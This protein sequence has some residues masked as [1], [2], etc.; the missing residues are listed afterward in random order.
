MQRRENNQD[1]LERK[2]CRITCKIRRIYA[3]FYARN[4]SVNQLQ[5]G[6]AYLLSVAALPSPPSGLIGE[7]CQAPAFY[8]RQH[9]HLWSEADC[10]TRLATERKESVPLIL[11]RQRNKNNNN[12][13]FKN[14]CCHQNLIKSTQL[15]AKTSNFN[16]RKIK[17]VFL[18][19]TITQS[20]SSL[21]Y[22]TVYLFVSSVRFGLPEH[23]VTNWLTGWLT[24][25]K[26]RAVNTTYGKSVRAHN[27]CLS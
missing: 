7:L 15:S 2:G 14:S 12:L 16:A 5:D 27:A 23:L 26:I 13:F 25:A 24:S 11:H 1:T 4:F 10:W 22:D 18:Y 8:L 19:T 17:S 21:R 6:G 20:I 9:D 3:G